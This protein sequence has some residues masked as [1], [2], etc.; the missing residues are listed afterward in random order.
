ML[1]ASLQWKRVAA[2][3]GNVWRAVLPAGFGPVPGLHALLPDGSTAEQVR[4]RFH[5]RI[6]R[7][8][9]P[10]HSWTQMKL[11]AQRAHALLRLRKFRAARA[12]MKWLT[13]SKALCEEVAQED[14]QMV[15]RDALHERFAGELA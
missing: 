5:M 9:S 1:P 7:P 2:T 13:Y 3:K 4:A 14:Q 12:A 6:K 10:L 8:R 15:V 11:A